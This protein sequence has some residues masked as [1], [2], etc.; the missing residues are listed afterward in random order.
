MKRRIFFWIE[1]LKITPAERKTVSGLAILLAVLGMINLALSPTV[2]FYGDHYHKLE[3]QF[4]KRTALLKKKQQKLMQRYHPSFKKSLATA[5]SD[6]VIRDSSAGK[7]GK[8]KP[9]NSQKSLINVNKAK[10]KTLE[11]LPGIGP[12]Y[13]GRILRYRKKYGRFNNIEEL[14]KIKGIAKKRLDNLKPFVKLTDST[15]AKK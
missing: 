9:K 4:Q 13:A 1:K 14:K 7:K 8:E 15:K 5:H 2:P 3:Q 11:S 10:K 6:T 12:A